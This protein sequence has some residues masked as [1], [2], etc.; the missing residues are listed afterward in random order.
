LSAANVH[1]YLDLHFPL[2]LMLSLGLNI[3]G[4]FWFALWRAALDLG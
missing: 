2:M 1:D 3:F 4:L